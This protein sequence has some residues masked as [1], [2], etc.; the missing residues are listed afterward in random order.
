MSQHPGIADG[1]RSKSDEQLAITAGDIIT[2]LTGNPVFPTPPIELE[3]VQAAVDEFNAALA[4]Q[5]LGGTAATAEKRIKK[6]ALI[7]ILRKL[8]RYVEDNCGNDAAVLLSS[9]FQAAVAT[10]T[11]RPLANPSILKVDRGNCGE[12]V[13]RVTPIALAPA[14]HPGAATCPTP[15]SNAI[16]PLPRVRMR[17]GWR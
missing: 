14:A 9:G 13:L 17:A 5:A 7:M 15:S 12:L 3:V 4:A 6:E 10:R 8:R 1:L 16:L 2:G 11:R